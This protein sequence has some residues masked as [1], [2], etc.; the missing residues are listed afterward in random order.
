MRGLGAGWCSWRGAR[1]RWLAA[2]LLWGALLALAL[3]RLQPPPPRAPSPPQRGL[4]QSE[5]AASTPALAAQA[6]LLAT[7]NRVVSEAELREEA[8]RR[9]PSLP[10]AYWHKHQN[11]KNKYYKKKTCAPFPSIYELEFHNTYWQTLRTTNGTFH[12]YG[13]YLDARNTSRIGPAVRILAVHDRIR[14]KLAT[15][16]QLWFEERAEPVVVRNLEYKYVWNSKWGN[17]RDGVLQPYLVACVLPPAVR[18]LV[19]ASVS[20]VELPC[21]RATNN[22]RVH[23]DRPLDRPRHEFAVCVKGLDFLHEDLSVRLVEWIELVRL[24][25]AHKVF[26]YELQ[27]HPNITK[28]L[29]YYE[30]LGVVSVTPITLPGGQPNL[31]GL[32]HMYL[33]KKTT[34]K[35]QMELIP[36]N[37]CLYRNM[38]HYRWLV[39]L[40]IDE[41]I[42]PLQ[43]EDWSALM[44]RV[45]PL[46][47]PAAGKPSRSS[48]HAS[49]LYFLDSLRHEHGWEDAVPRYMHM[50][51]HVYRTRN[52]TKPG[53]YVKA[54]HE[55]DRVLALH[56][57]FPLSCL[58]EACSSYSLPTEVARL[59]HYR[60]DCVTALSKTC[61]ELREQPVRDAALWRWRGLLVQRADA[62]LRALAFLP[63]APHR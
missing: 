13:A 33:K 22:L 5:P 52:F 51:Q 56:N 34:H 7:D 50:L 4:L 29:K 14:P 2:L 26:F 16:C 28:V 15:H 38:Y 41:V 3:P 60:A 49:N 30:E 19:P 42:V 40:D 25:G 18:G 37:D 27:V 44:R 21:D 45:L 9:L 55:T 57:H 23:Y 62:A 17:H 43:D 39:L 63:P 58:G 24:L 6:P 36:Y 35:R 31:P 32:Q 1:L 48:Y 12:L 46:S 59:Q 47:K 10:L 54:F 53:Q 20:L 11:D 61:K 8:E